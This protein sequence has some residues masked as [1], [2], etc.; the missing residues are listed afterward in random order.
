[1][2]ANSA[3]SGVARK[4]ANK[5]YLDSG[6]NG[7]YTPREKT[8][9]ATTCKKIDLSGYSKLNI[10]LS[11]VYKSSSSSI[12][13]RVKDTK[14]TSSSTSHDSGIA[15]MNLNNGICTLAI[16]NINTS[17]YVYVDVYASYSSTQYRAYCD[18]EQIWLEK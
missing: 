3:T 7:T 11:N 4:D 12:T 9:Y 16:G 2:K 15:S 6:T 17:A 18:I 8:V 1:M 14:P 10:K 13:L 5:I